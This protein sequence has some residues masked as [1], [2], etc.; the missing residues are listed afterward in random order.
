MKLSSRLITLVVAFAAFPT[1]SLASGVPEEMVLKT[2][3]KIW[4]IKPSKLDFFSDYQKVDFAGIN[5][6]LNQEDA[7]LVDDLISQEKISGIDSMK[8]RRYLETVIAPEIDREKTSVVID[9]DENGNITFDGTGFYG[10]K[11]DIEAATSMMEYA[12]KNDM[13]YMHLPLI[14]EEPDVTVLSE[15]LKEM[16]IK[17][18]FS[19]SET[20]FFGSSRDRIHNISTGL[21]KFQG[22]I[23]EPGEEFSYIENLGAVNAS[24]GYRKELVILGKET[25]PEF[26]GGLCQC[27]TTT[28][29]SALDGGLPVTARRN[30]SYLVSYYEPKGLDATIYIPNPDLKF[31]NDTPHHIVMQSFILDG[32]AYNNFYGIREDRSVHMI[33]P[34]Y[35]NWR[36]APAAVIEYSENLAPGQR[37]VLGHPVAGVD[38]TWY[39]QVTYNNQGEEGKSFLE[40]IYSRYQARPYFEVRGKEAEGAHEEGAE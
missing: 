38:V 14:V 1:F 30:H 35:A 4:E 8:V 33:G 31:V 5:V 10:R 19:S 3:F 32:K 28:Y 7:H 26:G 37:K 34:Y 12:L 15:K 36:S 22:L 39:R 27:S 23:L 6:S 17:E 29:R 18:R 24:T 16:G 2:N 40:T 13:K 21:S 20:T 25:R 9:M 11:L